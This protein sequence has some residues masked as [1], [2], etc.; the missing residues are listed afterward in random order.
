M[1]DLSPGGIWLLLDA[2]G[3]VS[4]IGLLSEGEWKGTTQEEGDFLEWHADATR[5]LLG[6]NSL[7]L[8][9]L[10]GAIYASG[11]GS[12]LGLRLAAMFIRSLLQVPALA[13]W[14]CL[15]YHN[16][17]LALATGGASRW[18][19][20]VAPWRRDC[21]HIARLEK[22]TPLGF[23]KD[24][25][26]IDEGRPLPAHGILLGRRPANQ[27]QAIEWHPYPARDIPA[28]IFAFPELL[29]A[30]D[31]PLPYV[32]EEPEFARWSPRRHGAE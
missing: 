14:Q 31:V 13:H 7:S 12:S 4:T 18:N 1:V 3:P 28:T 8:E 24:A 26:R 23:Q 22:R 6:E 16:L 27:L 19:E 21:L 2:A 10:S 29:T 20:L 17:E 9:D 32:A 11:P 15:Q 5:V 25:L 30:V